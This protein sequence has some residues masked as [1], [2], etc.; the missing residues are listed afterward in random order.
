MKTQIPT[1]RAKKIDS[2]M[3]KKVTYQDIGRKVSKVI[4]IQE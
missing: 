1:Y 4:G 3:S 2:D